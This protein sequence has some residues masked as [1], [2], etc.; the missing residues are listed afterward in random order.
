M[1]SLLVKQSRQLEAKSAFWGHF[2]KCTK[3]STVRLWLSFICKLKYDL[4]AC[5]YLKMITSASRKNTTWKHDN[6]NSY[7]TRA[8]EY[9]KTAL[10]YLSLPASKITAKIDHLVYTHDCWSTIVFRLFQ[11][12]LKFLYPIVYQGVVRMAFR[13]SSQPSSLLM[14]LCF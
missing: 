8:F 4:S 9:F 5:A 11:T 6:L 3:T 13:L 7:E 14:N 2:W 10:C 1:A 12:N